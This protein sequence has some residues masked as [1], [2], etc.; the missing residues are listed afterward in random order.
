MEDWQ[1][2]L[3][4]FTAW[5]AAPSIEGYLALFDPEATLQH[6]GMAQPISGDEI[7]AFISRGMDSAA[8]YRLVPTNWAARGDTLFVEARQNARIAGREVSWPAAL[9]LKLRGER[10]LVGRAYYDPH[11]G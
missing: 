7:R 11:I 2:Y 5:G 1:R 9:C 4:K 6:P 8:D 3:E 10:V